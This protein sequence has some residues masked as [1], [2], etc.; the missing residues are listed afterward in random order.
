MKFIEMRLIEKENKPLKTLI[1]DTLVVY[2]SVVIGYFIM[3][4][5]KPFSQE[6]AGNLLVNPPVFTDNPGF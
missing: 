4:Q 1:R 3:D 2:L 6:G 5:L